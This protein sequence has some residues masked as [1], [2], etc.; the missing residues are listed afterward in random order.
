MAILYD[1][2]I[3]YNEPSF[4]YQ[5][6]ILIKIPSINSQIQIPNAKIKIVAYE[7]MSNSSTIGIVSYNYGPTG[8]LEITALQ[9]Q[10]TAIVQAVEVSASSN[11]SG[12]INLSPYISTEVSVELSTQQ[13]TSTV[14]IVS[15]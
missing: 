3:S 4:S 6:S 2:N 15:I 9:E 8:I 10:A 14:G 11:F 12:V 5:G 13:S 7:D 1:D